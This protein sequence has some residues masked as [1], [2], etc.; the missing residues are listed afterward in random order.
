MF[1]AAETGNRLS[2]EEYKALATPLRVDLI[3]AQYDLRSQDWPVIILI[4]GDDLLGCERI[5]DLLNEWMDARCIDTHVF[6]EP[7]QEE[8]ERPRFWR[9]WQAIPSTGRCGLFLGAWTL[10]AIASVLRGQLDDKGFENR[11]N[12]IRRFEQDLRDNGALLLKFWLHLPKSEFK[13]RIKKAEKNGEGNWFLETKDWKIY[14]RYSDIIP[15][16][17]RYLRDSSGWIIV[18]STGSNYRDL[19]VAKIIRERIAALLE[20]PPQPQMISLPPVAAEPALDRVELTSSLTRDEYKE[21]LA[22]GQAKLFELSDQARKKGVSTVLAFEGWDAAGKGGVIRRITRAMPARNYRVVPIAA[23]TEEERMRHYLWRF[24]RQLP[25]AGH[26][27]IFDRTWYGRVLVE[28]VEGF[29]SEVEWLRAYEE[30]NDFEAQLVEHGMVFA[31]FWLHIDSDE[32]LSRF[33]AREETLYKKHKITDED[34]RNREKW[35]DYVTA[36][37]DMVARTSTKL[38]PWHL[39]PANDKPYARVQVLETVCNALK[40]RLS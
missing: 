18:E 40:K 37:N 20:T 25:R 21:R 38:A 39:V 8:L 29:A 6:E 23:P 1:K 4:M 14:K 32:Q 36:V 35:D 28:R 24:W 5:V 10:N 22:E 31:K 11:L 26:M 30:I 17:E 19:T 13:K 2:K 7:T 9:Y 12:H 3:N 15:I 34:Y 16:A 27:L 33:K